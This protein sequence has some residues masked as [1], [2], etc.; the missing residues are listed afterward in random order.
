MSEHQ[1]PSGPTVADENS[2]QEGGLCLVG[3]GQVESEAEKSKPEEQPSAAHEGQQT[4]AAAKQGCRTGVS[5]GAAQLLLLALFGGVN[6]R[7]SGPRACTRRSPTT[8]G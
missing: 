8:S 3:V 4:C 7:D 2:S 1:G 5:R 6:P